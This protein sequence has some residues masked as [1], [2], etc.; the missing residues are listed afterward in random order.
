[1]KWN[2]FILLVLCFVIMREIVCTVC[3]STEPVICCATCEALYCQECKVSVHEKSCPASQ[4][5][6]TTT[7]SSAE[8]A[9]KRS[10]Q[11]VPVPPKPQ[12]KTTVPLPQKTGRDDQ[13][14]KRKS[15]L[16]KESSYDASDSDSEKGSRDRLNTDGDFGY[17]TGSLDGSDASTGELLSPLAKDEQKT[18]LTP[19]QS[20]NG[21]SCIYAEVDLTQL[22]VAGEGSTEVQSPETEVEYTE[23]SLHR[24]GSSD[25]ASYTYVGNEFRPLIV[26]EGIGIAAPV[27]SQTTSKNVNTP[28]DNEVVDLCSSGKPPPSEYVEVKIVDGGFDRSNIKVVP[29]N[30]RTPDKENENATHI[31]GP[32][33]DLYAVVQK[34][35]K[36]AENKDNSTQLPRQS[37][38][39][40]K[41]I[42]ELG[43]VVPAIPGGRKDSNMYQAITGELQSMI[44]AC[45]NVQFEERS[46]RKNSVEKRTTSEN[47]RVPPP[48]PKPYAGSGLKQL[49][50]EKA[51]NGE[52]KENTVKDTDP[53]DC[54]VIYAT[55]QKPAR[56]EKSQSLE[57]LDQLRIPSPSDDDNDE[58]TSDGEMP[59]PLPSRLPNLE[60]TLKRTEKSE[61]CADFAK[62]EK[63][64][65][66]PKKGGALKLFK[67]KHRRQMSDGNLVLD[68]D[69]EGRLT[70]SP[71]FQH[72]RSKSQADVLNIVDNEQGHVRHNNATEMYTE[73]DI[74]P[75]KVESP[76]DKNQPI[77][78]Y[79]EVDISQ[80]PLTPTELQEKPII[81][82]ES[83]DYS[84]PYELPEGWKEVKS[85][86][87]TY[88]W[89]VASGT[90][91]WTLPQVATRPKKK[92]SEDTKSSE[93]TERQ[94]VLS[95]PVHSMGWIELEE[96][97]VAPHNMGDTIT[98]CIS[99][100]AELRKDLWNTSETWG[101][102][103]DI[104]LLLEGDAL[105][106][107]EP[108]TK[109]TLLVQPVSKMR[110]WGVGKE[111]QRDFAFVARDSSTGKHKC[112]MFRCHG[113]ISGRAITNAL[114]D[115]CSKILEKKKKAQESDRKMSAQ[116]PWSDIIN[117]PPPSSARDNASFNE[118]PHVEPKK[119]F[120]AKYA[121]SI[122]VSKPT[123]VEILN[124][125]INK[126]TS[127][128]GIWR[129]ILI[130]ISVSHIKITDCATQEMICEDRVRFMSFFGVGKDERLCGYIVSTAPEVFLCHVFHCTPNAAALTKALAE[131]CQLRFQKCVDAHPEIMQKVAVT[132]Q[133]KLK[134]KVEK[135][136]CEKDKAGF[137]TSVQGLLGKLGPKKGGGKKEEN[138]GPDNKSSNIPVITCKPTHTF[139]V[140]YYGALPVAVGTGIETV[141][142]AAK[143]L[144]GGTLLVCQLDVALNAV[145]LYDSQRSTLSKRNL[146]ADTISYCGLTSNGSHFGLIQSMGGGKYICHVFAEYKTKAAPIVAAIHETL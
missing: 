84:G 60:E 33:N 142:E 76:S 2:F 116:K 48:M 119:S 108:H 94:K 38:P 77:K 50:T 3:G 11:R 67:R 109:D 85:D 62:E 91:Q 44:I 124:K 130:E 102:G 36:G 4:Q 47:K 80:P 127:K 31:I 106:L 22:P 105:K 92:V 125:A 83:E 7:N 117:T 70:P 78:P 51:Q 58:D 104:R 93:A 145:T 42:V 128:G 54:Q 26:Q 98:N 79:M 69:M 131:A 110:V 43:D 68:K 16:R 132:E 86:S 39:M 103:K 9:K 24:Q 46:S 101:E 19:S 129:T 55:V 136:K 61:N 73:I 14:T 20:D 139:M 122:D 27:K 97:Q 143:H 141:E 112:H 114:H 134:E 89:H 37:S 115:L 65:K 135:D 107:V 15:E 96:S 71:K 133:E 74:Q 25:S 113:S 64:E 49:D 88:Y 95:F 17:E 21:S 10:P 23:L 1:M 146:D 121:G 6:K 87:G 144:A 123:G 18:I 66:K 63:V 100:L 111:D 45:D 13:K 30:Q 34:K 40:Q 56:T 32:K 41:P 57:S 82:G 12:S 126:L 120:S 35:S 138:Q 90:T 99:S 52:A 59:P 140:K 137:M 29:S 28:N 5:R 53:Q 118:K 8:S 75:K 72:Q 81:G